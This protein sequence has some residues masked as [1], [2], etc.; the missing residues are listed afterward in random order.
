MSATSEVYQGIF[1]V[2]ELAL[3]S[4]N[5]LQLYLW[6]QYLKMRVMLDQ[7][8]LLRRIFADL[9]VKIRGLLANQ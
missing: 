7:S 5:I 3:P 2:V 8:G 9:D 1:H 6:W 4:R